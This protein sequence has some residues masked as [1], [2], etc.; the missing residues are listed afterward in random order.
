[1]LSDYV[2][3]LN[4]N[5]MRQ[6]SE[7]ELRPGDI[8]VIFKGGVADHV[9]FVIASDGNGAIRTADGGQNSGVTWDDEPGT[10][11]TLTKPSDS[12]YVWNYLHPDRPMT[13]VF[14]TRYPA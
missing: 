4:D 7:S 14:Y 1:M 8:M 2:F 3:G 13:R 5:P 6:V 10:T 12:D 9:A 11:P